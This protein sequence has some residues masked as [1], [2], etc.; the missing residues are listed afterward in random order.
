MNKRDFLRTAGGAGLGLLFGPKL[1]AEYARL[2]A[3][4]LATQEDFWAAIRGKYRLKPD[5]VNLESG[6]YSMQAEP[7]LEIFIAKV[8]ETNYENSY[9]FRTK[10]VPDKAAVRDKLAAMAGC[11]PGELCITRNTTESLDTVISGYD[12]KPGDEAVMAEQDYGHM[13]AQFRL[14]ARRHGMVNK[15]VSLPMDPKSDDEVVQLYANAITPRTRLL[16]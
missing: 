14:M 13:L 4:A 9:Y 5:Y 16:M 11:A 2:P 3:P 7:V 8:R 6:Y 10:Q 15:V 1:W 12:W